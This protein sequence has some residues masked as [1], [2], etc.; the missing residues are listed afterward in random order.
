MPSLP[1]DPDAVQQLQAE[2]VLLLEQY[3][4]LQIRFLAALDS[5]VLLQQ[6][7]LRCRTCRRC[8][9]LSSCLRPLNVRSGIEE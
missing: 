5:Q 3:A 4:E 8:R 9:G 7:R 6:H 1:P 2:Y